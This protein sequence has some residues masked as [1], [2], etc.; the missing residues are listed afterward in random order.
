MTNKHNIIIG[1]AGGTGAGKTTLADKILAVLGLN[2][3]V[4][5]RQ[6]SYYKDQTDKLME[7]RIKT[8]YDHPVAFDRELLIFHIER[9]RSGYPIEQP[10]YDYKIHTRSQE[11]I[12]IE[13]NPVII[14]EGILILE[15][16]LLRE[17]MDIK[18]FVDADADERIIRRLKRDILER[19]RDFENVTK[20]YLD[21]VKPMHLEFIEPSKRYA[22]IIV[23]RGGENII[24]L[25]MI[26]S[27]IK[28]LLREK[29]KE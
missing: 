8:N 15:D 12:H 22:D 13:P 3:V 16:Y 25:N 26:V 19:G 17:L 4:V 29:S 20:Q 11:T 10:I 23:P 24:A 5:I 1:V 14:L 2:V 28:S 9:L 6:D 7:E 27:R 18:I 21:T